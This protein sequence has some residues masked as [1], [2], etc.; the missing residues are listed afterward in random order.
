MAFQALYGYADEWFNRKSDIGKLA[1]EI[2][3]DKSIGD[4]LFFMTNDK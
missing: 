3:N 1:G 2:T 4:R